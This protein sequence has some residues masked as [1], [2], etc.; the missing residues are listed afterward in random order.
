MRTA[1][2]GDEVSPEQVEQRTAIY[3]VLQYFL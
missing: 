2:P 3:L 1:I